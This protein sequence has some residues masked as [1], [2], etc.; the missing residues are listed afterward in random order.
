MGCEI[1]QDGDGCL[2]RVCVPLNHGHL[3][4]VIAVGGDNSKDHRLRHLLAVFGLVKFQ[5]TLWF[6]LAFRCREISIL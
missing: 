5:L 4:Y 2:T 3:V 6:R 1:R